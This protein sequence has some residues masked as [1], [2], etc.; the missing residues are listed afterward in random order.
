VT[1]SGDW[2][3]YTAQSGRTKICYA[4]TEPKERL[5]KSLSRDP[6]YLFVS[7]RPAEKV[8]NEIALVLGF[9]ANESA[10]A[11]ASIGTAKY[12]LLTKDQDAWLKNPA[13]EGQAIATMSKGTAL[14]V[15][16]L[17][18]RG[19]QLTDRYSLTGFGPAL[20]RA[21]KECS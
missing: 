19:N 7:F 8:R 21:R 15:K 1:S 6:A 9:A 14:L 11:Q 12:T 20:E 13:E 3:V 4:L 5:P 16:A 18:R 2:R 17:S 10:A